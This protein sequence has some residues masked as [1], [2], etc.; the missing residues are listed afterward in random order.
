MPLVGVLM[1]VRHEAP[2]AYVYAAA[3]TCLPLLAVGVVLRRPRP[4]AVRP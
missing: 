3:G 4:A 2:Y 1:N